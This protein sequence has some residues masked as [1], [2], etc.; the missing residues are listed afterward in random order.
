[1]RCP[2]EVVIG[3]SVYTVEY[4]KQL[5]DENEQGLYGRTHHTTQKILISAEY[6]ESPLRETLLHEILHCIDDWMNLKL[7]ESQTRQLSLALYEILLRNPRV[8][9]WMVD[10]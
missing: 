6:G 4:P 3:P 7:R 10:K 2:A 8:F 5:R 1:M 9:L